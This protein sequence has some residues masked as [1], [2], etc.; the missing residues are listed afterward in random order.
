M[1]HNISPPFEIEFQVCIRLDELSKVIQKV[2]VTEG[3]CRFSGAWMGA[4]LFVF[5][6]HDKA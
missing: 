4:Y 6:K 3:K 1:N 2:L 5:V